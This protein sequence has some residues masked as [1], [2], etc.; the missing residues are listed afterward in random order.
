ML[1]RI[2]SGIRQ[3]FDDRDIEWAMAGIALWW[4]FTVS[5]PGTAWV[6]E[7]AWIGM[8]RAAGFFGIAPEAAEDTVGVL[9]MLAGGFWIIA[10]ALNGTFADTV[11][12]RYSP[13]VR[14][15][16]AVGSSAVWFQVVMSVSAVQTSGS[17]MYPLPL[18][19][20]LLCVRNAWRDIGEQR[21]TRHAANLRGT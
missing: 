4:G 21:R 17:G 8:I 16:A 19:L 20:S 2:V 18:V 3:H 12:A 14:G 13:W 11:Y 1:L 7:P 6:N 5:Q 9:T 10:L 15:I